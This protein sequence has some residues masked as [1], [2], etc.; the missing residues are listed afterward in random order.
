M[1]NNSWIAVLVVLAVVGLA[2]AS[3]NG[4]SSTVIDFFLDGTAQAQRPGYGA[5]DGDGIAITATDVAGSRVDFTY[6]VDI[7]DA[8]GPNDSATTTGDSGLEF[9]AGDLTLIRGWS[10]LRKSIIRNR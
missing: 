1:T 3:S 2:I 6:S 7:L 10:I 9:V 8:G 5:S 4:V